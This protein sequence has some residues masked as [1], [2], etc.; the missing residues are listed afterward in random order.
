MEYHLVWIK[1]DGG[2]FGSGIWGM[3]VNAKNKEEACSIVSK[4]YPG[5][6]VK[7]AGTNVMILNRDIPFTWR[8][9]DDWIDFDCVERIAE[10]D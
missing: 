6:Q 9:P 7:Y 8:A 5:A 10:M 4:K 1:I 3:F 2:T